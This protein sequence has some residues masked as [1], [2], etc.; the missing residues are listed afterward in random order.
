MTNARLSVALCSCVALSGCVAS[1]A[2]CPAG[3]ALV[4]VDPSP[5]VPDHEIVHPKTGV[6]LRCIMPGTFTMGT[7]GGDECCTAH[8]RRIERPFYIGVH[9]VSVE[10]WQR[11]SGG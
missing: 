3:S 1:S 7:R 8:P 9:E 2:P 5:Y 11:G 4:A 6:R 10:Q